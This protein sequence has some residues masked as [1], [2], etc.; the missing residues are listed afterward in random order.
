MLIWNFDHS[1]YL[2]YIHNLQGPPLAGI[3]LAAKNW[4]YSYPTARDA[5]LPWVDAWYGIFRTAGPNGIFFD[6]FYTMAG[7]AGTWH[8]IDYAEQRAQV[9]VVS[10]LLRRDAYGNPVR[11]V[12]GNPI[13]DNIFY[14]IYLVEWA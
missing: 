5:L 3:G 9:G 2:N 4:P 1:N 10:D 8:S 7:R 14:Q 11:D 6:T 12:Y 13:F